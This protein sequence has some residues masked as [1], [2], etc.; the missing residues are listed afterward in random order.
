M[1]R[2]KPSRTRFARSSR[3]RRNATA[4]ARRVAPTSR[5][6][7]TTRRSPTACSRSTLACS[8]VDWQLRIYEI[9]PGQIEAW[10]HE[11]RAHIAPLRRRLGFHVLGPWLD[12][13]TFVWM[14]GYEGD[15]GFAAADARYYAST[16]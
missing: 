4:E 5:R 1:R 11:W 10:L 3:A 12:G 2:R 9:E 15:D 16:E 13:A 8:R 6:C 14:L 7:T